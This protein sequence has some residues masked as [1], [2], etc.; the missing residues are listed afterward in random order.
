MHE[1]DYTYQVYLNGRFQGEFDTIDQAE[2]FVQYLK[3]GEI[4]PC[5]KTTKWTD[6]L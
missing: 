6:A 1:D 2:G 4:I 3:G 5:E